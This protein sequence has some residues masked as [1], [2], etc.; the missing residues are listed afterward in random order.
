MWYVIVDCSRKILAGPHRVDARTDIERM[1]HD[2]FLQHNATLQSHGIDQVLVLRPTNP[3]DR[4]RLD[5]AQLQP[6]IN[7]LFQ[8]AH[9][10]KV[11]EGVQRTRDMDL[12]NDEL[13]IVHI[14]RERTCF[15]LASCFHVV[16][17]CLNSVVRRSLEAMSRQS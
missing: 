17:T 11:L 2:I 6:I 7:E 12:D 8:D 14:G 1:A 9:R 5:N 15:T 16:L 4:T 10:L 3:V 13:L